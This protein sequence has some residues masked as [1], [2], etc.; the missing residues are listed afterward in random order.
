MQNA[1]DETSPSDNNGANDVQVLLAQPFCHAVPGLASG[2]TACSFS[3]AAARSPGSPVTVMDNQGRVLKTLQEPPSKEAL[4]AKATEE[5]RQRG[6]GQGGH[7]TGAKDRILLDSYTAGGGDRSRSQPRQ[8]G[9]RAAVEI[10]RATWRRWSSVGG[11]AKAE[12]RAGREGLPRRKSRSS[13]GCRQSVEA[14]ARIGAPEKAGSRSHYRALRGR[15]SVAGRRSAKSSARPV[16]PRPAQRPRNNDRGRRRHTTS[17]RAFSWSPI[18][19]RFASR[20]RPI[21]AIGWRV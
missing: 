17:Q 11:A 18:E 7:G 8:P 1:Q 14:Q 15:R 12:G 9:A 16:L 3:R 2:G 20:H 21:N 4:A 5:E 6:Q 13:P 10:A 19:C